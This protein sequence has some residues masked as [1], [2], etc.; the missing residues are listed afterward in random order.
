VC[1]E[2]IDGGGGAAGLQDGGRWSADFCAIAT[3][4]VFF[5]VNI[6]RSEV[7]IEVRIEV[8]VEAW[9]EVRVEVVDGVRRG[10]ITD[11]MQ[12]AGPELASSCARV[13]EVTH[14]WEVALVI[15]GLTQGQALQNLSAA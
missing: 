11:V 10:E 9:I 12:C 15:R 14:A 2:A 3:S 5:F 8:R 4:D 13:C 6:A 7:R 1:F